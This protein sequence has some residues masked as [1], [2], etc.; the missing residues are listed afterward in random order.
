MDRKELRKRAIELRQQ[1]LTYREIR[2]KIG[3]AVPKGTLSGWLS[4][5][6]LSEAAQIRLKTTQNI[7]IANS[8]NR[9][10]AVAANKLIRERYFRNIRDKNSIYEEA[11]TNPFQAKIALAMLYLGE[12]SKGTQ[13][14]CLGL[15]NADPEIITLYLQLLDRCYSI[16][17][18]KFRLKIQCRADQNSE[19]LMLYWSSL[20]GIPL[21][22]FYRTYV[23]QRTLNKPTLKLDYKGVCMVY[24][25]SAD[26][27]HD[28]MTTINILMGR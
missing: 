24:Y 2:E 26:T 15:A 18:N 4:K 8:Q 14:A 27:F 13:R 9:L 7:A 5:V 17:R 11:L 28:I 23:D 21:Q 1:G 19:E 10:L 25:L 22:Q 6:I 20:T 12:G 3:E 16:D